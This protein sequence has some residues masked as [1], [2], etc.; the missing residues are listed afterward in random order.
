MSEELYIIDGHA[1][2]Y[3]AFYAVESLRSPTGEPVNA[4]FQFTRMLLHLIKEKKPARIVAVFDAPGKNFRHELYPEYKANRKPAPEELKVQIPQIISIVKDF[5]IPVLSIEGVE[6]DDVIGVLTKI[7]QQ[8]GLNSTIVSADKDLAQLLNDKVRIF[9]PKKNTLTTAADFYDENGFEPDKLVDLMGLWGDTADN[10]PGVAGIGKKIGRELIQKYKS[11]EN[12]LDRASEIKGKRGETLLKSRE[13]ALLSKE[14]A[15]IKLDIPLDFDIEK[16]KF[17]EPDYTALRNKF[18]EYGFKVLLSELDN[19][20]PPPQEEREYRLID[21][22][23]KFAA[24]LPELENAGHFALDT[25]TTG[26][27]PVRAELVGIS[28]SFT[29]KTAFYLPFKGL[30]EEQVLTARELTALK[31]ILENP[32]ITKCGQNLKYDLIIFKR[33]GV[34]VQGVNFDTLIASSLLEGHIR[35]HDLDSLAARHLGIEKIPT[36]AIIGTGSKE[37]T[38]DQAGTV[39]VCEYAC[40]DA[41]VTL[42]LEKLFRSRLKPEEERLLQDIELPLS[43]L[44]TQMQLE[45]IRVDGELL[46]KQ[47]RELEIVLDS[48]TTRIYEIAGKEFNISSTKQLSEIMFEDLG[49]P[50][51]RKTKTGC[52]TDESVLTEL[53]GQGYELPELL[54]EFRQYSKLKSTYLDAL[55][56]MIN[57]ETGRI[58]TTFSQTGTATGRLSSNN[59]NL[60]NIPIRS[61][62]GRAIRAAFIPR[63]GWKMLAADYSQVELRMLAHFS[64]DIMLVQAFENNEDIHRVVAAEINGIELDAVTSEQR[65]AA[66]AVNFGIIYGQTAHGLSQTTGMPRFAAQQFIDSYFAQFPNIRDFIDSTIAQAHEDGGVRTM[67]GRFRALPELKASKKVDMQRGEREALNTLI[68]GSAADLIKIAMLRVNA[69]ISAEGLEARMLLQ[70]HDELVFEAAAADIPALERLVKRE[71]EGA[72]K[73]NVPLKVEIGIG[74]NWLALK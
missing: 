50:V 27:D 20:S 21:T 66:K 49:Y 1:Q 31:P 14:L 23:E 8:N 64:E 52:S 74:D 60:Q 4:I 13:I 55:P 32:Q 38:M 45:G 11:L 44:L 37:I 3:R 59:P 35:G 39:T 6:A 30:P 7:A 69:A 71:M 2:I 65:Y 18:I 56:K 22:P 72:V 43:R 68:Q 33:N 63:D 10:I 34:D 24:F 15:T 29:E 36:K 40:E 9:D 58:H 73:L 57:P 19:Q 5:N 62:K 12:L 47:S 67:Y 53:A 48:I 28:V 17:S 46:Q 25:E 61:E 41:D 54:L 16:T 26:I 42:R 70:I 51:I